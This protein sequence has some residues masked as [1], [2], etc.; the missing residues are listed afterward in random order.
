MLLVEYESRLG[1]IHLPRIEPFL[2][3]WVMDQSGQNIWTNRYRI[4]IKTLI[5]KQPE[6]KFCSLAHFE[7]E[8]L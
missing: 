5:E 8:M 4:C 1:L 2:E 6:L 3:L 7:N